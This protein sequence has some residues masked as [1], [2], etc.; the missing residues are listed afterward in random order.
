M[1]RLSLPGGWL[2]SEMVYLHVMVTH[3]STGANL[4]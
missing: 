2:Y 3:L 1:T 4:A